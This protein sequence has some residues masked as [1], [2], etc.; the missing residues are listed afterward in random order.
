M[1]MKSVTPL[2]LFFCAATLCPFAAPVQE[3]PTAQQLIEA[4][5]IAPEMFSENALQVIADNFTVPSA[6]I[7]IRC[8]TELCRSRQNVPDFVLTAALNVVDVGPV[9]AADSACLLLDVHARINGISTLQSQLPLLLQ[10]LDRRTP[11][12]L[13]RDNLAGFDIPRII[14]VLRTCMDA[15]PDLVLAQ[16]RSRLAIDREDSR[17]STAEILTTLLLDFG[18]SGIDPLQA[19]QERAGAVP[20][21]G[22]VW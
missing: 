6:P 17:L 8:A 22:E 13:R 9:E 12:W 1:K 4:A 18:H 15:D 3:A 11:R 10:I 16:F 2:L 20:K 5:R 14:A 21:L 19:G 7:Y